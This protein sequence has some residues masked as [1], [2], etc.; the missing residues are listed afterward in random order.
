M[1]GIHMDHE[2][3]ARVLSLRE[4]GAISW[5]LV[6]VLSLIGCI[7]CEVLFNLL[8]FD[9]NTLLMYWFYPASL[10][11][12]SQL[13]FRQ[14]FIQYSEI[15]L[16]F[17]ILVWSMITVVVNFRRAQIVDSYQWFITA[18]TA[19]FLCF[20]LPYAFEKEELGRIL[21]LLAVAGLF[22]AALL[23]LAG[24]IAVFAE[25]IAAKFP[26]IFEGVGIWSGRLGLDNHPNRSAPAPA[27]GVV[28]AII[29]AAAAKKRWQSWLFALCG[30]ICFVPLALT[31]S[32]TAILAAGIALGFIAF[33]SLREALRPR[34]HRLLCWIL[35]SLAALVVLVG[36]YQGAEWTARLSNAAIEKQEMQTVQ[37]QQTQQAQEVQEEEVI[38]RD[39]SDADSFNGRTDIWFA[40]VRGML[41]NPELIAFGT[42]P[43]MSSE[44]MAPYFPEGSPVGI[45][46]NS[47][48]GAFVAYGAVGLL[49]TLL[50]LGF[51]ATAALRLSFGK[52]NEYPLWMRFLPAVLLF[53]LADS[54]MEDFLFENLS[55]NIVCVWFMLAAGFVLRLTGKE[56][57]KTAPKE[58]A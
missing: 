54:M 30:L 4:G 5:R 58:I 52:Q 47:L 31:V 40:V 57:T 10:L 18:S 9:H 15:K 45:F 14:S 16:L 51:V 22:A 19:A 25:P 27:L 3:G 24:L 50:L 55:L 28:F 7:A 42:G 6:A 33:L 49:L 17:A 46:H 21:R 48:V 37:T 20:S 23:S 34:M 1:K 44:V 29:L 32:R 53:T 12:A 13:Y 36:V 2:K 41:Q 43:V 26:S 8:P 39:L 38:E 35:C 11:L 56:K